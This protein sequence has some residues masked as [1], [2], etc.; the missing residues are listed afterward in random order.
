MRLSTVID[1]A[2]LAY[3][4]Q[5][6]VTQMVEGPIRRTNYAEIAARALERTRARLL[7][8]LAA[9]EGR[10]IVLRVVVVPPGATYLGAGAR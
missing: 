4:G 7:E 1:H 3:G 5:E 8:A 10:E 6:V 2:A 9:T